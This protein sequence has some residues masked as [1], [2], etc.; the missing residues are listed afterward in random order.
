MS[1][2]ENVCPRCDFVTLD[3]DIKFCPKCGALLIKITKE[4]ED[5]A[6]KIIDSKIKIIRVVGKGGMGLICE[7]EQIPL[8]RR[9]AVKLLR[10][11]LY[12]DTQTARRFLKEA[13][14]AARLDHPNIIRVIDFGQTPSG[15][16]YLVMEYL[17]GKTLRDEIAKKGILSLARTKQIAEAVCSALSH[18]HA[19][20][21]IH[22][23]LKPENIFLAEKNNQEVIV[24]LDFGIAKIIGGK[25]QTTLGMVAGTAEYMSP[26][27]INSQ[28]LDGRTDLYSLACVLYECL[29]GRPPYVG[30]TPLA[31]LTMHLQGKFKP[32]LE[33][34]PDLNRR[35]EIFFK[36]ALDRDISQRYQN[37]EEFKKAFLAI[38]EKDEKDEEEIGITTSVEFPDFEPWPLVLRQKPKIPFYYRRIKK[39]TLTFVLGIFTV[40]VVFAFV[41][42][43]LIRNTNQG[44]VEKDGILMSVGAADIIEIEETILTQ[45][46]VEGGD[47][48]SSLPELSEFDDVKEDKVEEFYE[49]GEAASIKKV[50]ST[51]SQVSPKPPRIHKKKRKTAEPPPEPN[52]QLDWKEEPKGEFQIKRY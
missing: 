38:P 32:I 37:A 8:E 47:L 14:A 2:F 33:L 52:P 30:N 4:D 50:V 26:E 45:D 12:Y 27:Q 28:H 39:K 18:A 16:L 35:I 11:E 1:A 5:W 49:T 21:V 40:L 13:R 31:I 3:L 9:V 41:I 6:G 15:V 22:C 17:V 20:K 34:R 43:L 44:A 36:H 29:S 48:A 25:T 24:V 42:N 51:E 10:K 46:F 19:S 7:A 23:D